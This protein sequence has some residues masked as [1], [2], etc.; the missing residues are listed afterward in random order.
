MKRMKLV[1]EIVKEPL[2]GA[3]KDPA[4]TFKAVTTAITKAYAQLKDLS[5]KDSTKIVAFFL[6]YL[7]FSLS[8]NFLIRK[9][10]RQLLE[11]MFCF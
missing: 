4:S 7:I 3:H 9:K 2:G 8:F 11:S 10:I 1:D 5:P 6:K